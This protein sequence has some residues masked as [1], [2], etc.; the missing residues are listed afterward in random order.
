MTARI[1][2]FAIFTAFFAIG[3]TA[4]AAVSAGGPCPSGLPASGNNCYFVAANGSDSN[5]GTSETTPWLHAPGMPNC[6]SN[7]KAVTPSPGNGF[8]F[9]GGDTWHFGI[10]TDSANNP[11]SGG[12]WNISNWAGNNASC[13]YEG[14]TSG[15]IYW[16]AD[17]TWYSGSSWAHPILNGDNPTST[18]LVSSCTYQV[19]ANNNAVGLYN[20]DYFDYF[21][22]KGFCSSRNPAST[23]PGQDLWIAYG[24]TGNI[25]E[26]N[27]Y[28]HGWTATTTAGQM[29]NTIPCT[30]LGGSTQGTAQQF[31]IADVID[32]SDSNAGACAWGTFPMFSHMK[33]S[34]IRYTTQGV[35]Q[36]CHD[37]HDNIFEYI[38]N[39]N[40]PTHGNILECNGDA[41][42]STPNVFYNNV[43]RHI[44]SNFFS[45]G[46]VGWW[47]CPNTV[48]EYWFN[49]IVYDTGGLGD[50]NLWAVAG[51][52]QYGNCTSTGGQFMF[53][54]TL[55][56][57]IQPCHMQGSNPTGGAYTTVYNEHLLNTPWDGTGCT[58]RNDSSNISM[59]W[60]TG[61]SQGYTKGSPGI[62]DSDTCANETT[63]CASIAST[64]STVGAGHNLTNNS[65][66]TD[67]VTTTWCATLASFS[68]E[69][70][71]GTEAATA[72]KYGTTDG[73]AYNLSSHAMVCPAQTAVARPAGAWD[74]GAYQ[75]STSQTQ[76]LH[77]PTGLSVL[78][79]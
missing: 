51:T 8:I 2:R 7:C 9:R 36:N 42:G 24:G 3:G 70:A 77:P 15:C 68:S 67:A 18:S 72:C 21:E 78:V 56:G 35:G 44:N 61:D 16:G 48:A 59:T 5:N 50:G 14:T 60:A 69:Y 19:G 47:F 34:I 45:S 37:I 22:M 76:T 6:A 28:I 29:N 4:F 79:Q 30:L 63:P 39:P 65:T 17:K 54:N 27:L 23:V 75:Y 55:S 33:D 74:A 31:L 73:C 10:T 43:M 62:T 20:G 52:L 26:T 13:L 58:G 53:N 41:Q 38:S 40:L 12:Q 32:G 49:N 25:F 64:N 1:L 71:I 57:A 46:Q 11:A 66:V